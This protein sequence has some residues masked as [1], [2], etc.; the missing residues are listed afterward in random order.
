MPT[1]TP[2]APL[3]MVISSRLSRCVVTVATFF[4]PHRP[5]ASRPFRPGIPGQNGAELFIRKNP[6]QCAWA[7]VRWFVRVGV[8]SVSAISQAALLIIQNCFWRAPSEK[9]QKNRK[10]TEPTTSLTA[11][12][13]SLSSQGPFF[14]RS[15][16]T[17]VPSQRRRSREGRWPRRRCCC[18]RASEHAHAIGA[19]A[20]AAEIAPRSSLVA[21]GECDAG[22]SRAGS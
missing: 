6:P 15:K 19:F 3:H 22:W 16:R 12:R 11:T 4:F 7:H 14:F 20:R 13:H 2:S 9:K 18:M 1:T 8:L 21:A 10:A 5:I 17:S